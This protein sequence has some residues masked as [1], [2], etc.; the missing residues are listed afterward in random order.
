MAQN[1]TELPET[2]EIKFQHHTVK[3]KKHKVVNPGGFFGNIDWIIEWPKYD[4]NS[5]AILEKHGISYESF[6]ECCVAELES[7]RD[8]LFKFIENDYS[9]SSNDV[10]DSDELHIPTQHIISGMPEFL[11]SDVCWEIVNQYIDKIRDCK[12]WGEFS[13]K[14]TKYSVFRENMRNKTFRA[15]KQW[16]N[17]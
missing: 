7:R 9:F 4:R 13:D 14:M 10:S 15:I 1:I 8:I 2:A 12:N 5:L 11:E 16:Y 6:I 17:V 3:I